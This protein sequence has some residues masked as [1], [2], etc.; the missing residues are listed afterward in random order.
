MKDSPEEIKIIKDFWNQRAETHGDECNAT[1]GEKYLRFLEIKTMIKLIKT[2]KPQN[3]LDVGCGN[4]YSTIK[5]AKTF[6]DI[7]FIGIDYSEKMIRYAKK[8]SLPNSSFFV[9]DVMEP[10]SFPNADFDLILT[11]RCIQNLGRYENQYAAISNLIK[12]KKPNGLILLMEC[13]KDGVEQLNRIRRKLRKKPKEGIEPWH[14][15]FIRD[16][17]LSKDF[18]AEIVYFSSTYMFLTK[19]LHH[20]LSKLGYLLPNMGNFGY[21]RL[22]I[23]K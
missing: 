23:I 13:S 15:N 21:D 14:N 16:N 5:Y 19:V 8:I 3:V 20:R 18:G 1:L 9:A 11:Q 10:K 12:K 7:S 6:P 17:K 4:G 2:Y 22:Y